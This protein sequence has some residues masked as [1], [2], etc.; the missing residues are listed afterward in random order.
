MDPANLAMI[1]GSLVVAGGASFLVFKNFKAIKAGLPASDELSE[2]QGYKAA[3]FAYLSS[4]WVAVL[5]LWFNVFADNSGLTQLN[6]GQVVG[7]VVLIPGI[8]FLGASI[9]L[10]NKGV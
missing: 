10:N 5:A 9:Y 8:I 7:A 6:A 3:Y 2:K 1:I 4:V